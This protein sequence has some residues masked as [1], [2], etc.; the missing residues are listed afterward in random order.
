MFEKFL[1]VHV[2]RFPSLNKARFPN[3]GARMEYNQMHSMR[4]LELFGISNSR[5]SL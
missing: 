1:K 3:Q 2:P 4:V 5:P